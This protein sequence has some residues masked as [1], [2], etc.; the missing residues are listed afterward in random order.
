MEKNCSCQGS[1]EN[2]YRCSGRGYYD[3]KETTQSLSIFSPYA[4]QIEAK[5]SKNQLY[6]IE[7]LKNIKNFDKPKKSPWREE[8]CQQCGEIIYIHEDWIKPKLF[9]KCC[10]QHVRE[11][12]RLQKTRRNMGNPLSK[13]TKKSGVH[14]ISTPFETNK[15]RH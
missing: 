6:L 14:L 2:C 7:T 3:D 15:R 9:C 13:I 11:A 4:L 8:N 10:S 1:N 12:R 5:P